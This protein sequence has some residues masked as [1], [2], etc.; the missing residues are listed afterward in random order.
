[1]TAGAEHRASGIT[2]RATLAGLGAMV[3]TAACR[4]RSREV[5]S[6]WA[7]GRE[8]EVASRL[9]EQFAAQHPDIPVEIQK[10]PWTAAHEKLLTAYA[11]DTLPDVCQLGSTWVAEFAALNALEPL[12]ARLAGSRTVQA[13]DFFPGVLEANRLD[14]QLLGVPWYVDTRLL[15]YRRDLLLRAGFAA[16]P[17]SWAEWTQVL[18]ALKQQAGK[19][20]YAILLPLNEFEQLLIL[21]LQQSDELLREGGRWGNFRSDGFRRA[22]SFY[23]QMFVREWA[24]RMTNTQIAN[25]WDE[26]ARGYFTFYVSGPWQIAEFKKRMPPHLQ[27]SWMTAPMPGPEGPGV[28]VAGGASLVVF[29]NSQLKAQAWQLVEFLSTV[30]AQTRFYELTGD[31]PTRRTPWTAPALAASP[32]AQ[33][34]RQQLDR[35]RAP[36]KVPEWARI[37]EELRLMAERV[38]QGRND[39]DTAAAQMDAT[40]D[41]ILEKRRWLLA[42]RSGA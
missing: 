13:E 30:P 27:D 38:V 36:P 1:M 19:D 28:S 40:V 3:G 29:R 7:I 23:Q 22:L 10:L 33:A 11:G 20:R 31:L 14:G 34:F 4:R 37:A 39:V 26:F 8:G 18:T 6:F 32:H 15:F 17:V 12:D 2:R 41:A 24:P 42:R 9:L 5:L 21:A 16:P 25:V 35:V